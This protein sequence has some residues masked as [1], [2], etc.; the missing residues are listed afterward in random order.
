MPV[1]DS[2]TC[3]VLRPIESENT[4]DI[5]DRLRDFVSQLTGIPIEM[6]RKRWLVKPGRRPSIDLNW[7]AVG[8]QSVKTWGTPYQKGRKGNVDDPNS[9]DITKEG[10]QTLVCVASFY[11]PDAQAISDTFREGAYLG[12]NNS[13]LQSKGLT[14]QGVD[15]EVRHLPDFAFEQWIDRFDVTFRVGRKVSRTYGVR[16]IASADFEIITEKGNI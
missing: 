11:G 9:G 13:Y 15:E 7:C 4:Q 10:H 3:G 12:Q 6:V 16:T 8:V 2:R 1:I 14:I 5:T